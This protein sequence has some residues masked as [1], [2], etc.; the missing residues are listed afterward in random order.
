MAVIRPDRPRRPVNFTLD[1]MDY[2]ASVLN[3]SAVTQ[4]RK[5][6]KSSDEACETPMT[7]SR[8]VFCKSRAWPWGEND[9]AETFRNVTGLAQR[10]TRPCPDAERR[11]TFVGASLTFVFSGRQ[12]RNPWPLGTFERRQPGGSPGCSNPSATYPRQKLRQTLPATRQSGLRG[13]G[14][15]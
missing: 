4:N 1:R 3:E 12:R 8:P 10:V 6:R 9:S 7:H 2:L 13:G 15:T 5:K 14:L 11:W